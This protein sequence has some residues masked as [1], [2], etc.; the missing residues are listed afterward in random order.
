MSRLVTAMAAAPAPDTVSRMSSMR[1]PA[2]STALRKAAPAMMA[3]P[4]WSS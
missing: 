4:C 2:I 3:V 1:L